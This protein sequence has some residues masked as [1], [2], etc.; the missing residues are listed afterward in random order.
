LAT[1]LM[2]RGLTLEFFYY[3]M[4]G[5]SE[6]Q[7]ADMRSFWTDFHFLPSLPHPEPKFPRHW[8]IDDWCPDVLCETVA[9]L[10]KKR[11]YDAI[12][13]NYVWMS[14]VLEGLEN[15]L[16]IIDT[17]DLFGDRH[18]IS[19]QEGLEPRWFFTS[20]AEEE[21]GFRRADLLIGIQAQETR[22]IQE[23]V[24]VTAITVGHCMHPYF[25]KSFEVSEPLATFGYL[26]SANPWNIK[27]I[28]AL[29]AAL[30]RDN[31][32]VWMLAGS[33]TRRQLNLISRPLILGLVENLVDFYR[34]VDCV[35]NPMMGGTGLKIKTVEALAYG[36]SVIG[37]AD[38]FEGLPALHGFQKLG[39]AHECALAMKEYANSCR[40]REELRA[41]SRTAYLNYA[42]IV[43]REL[44]TLSEMIG[45]KLTKT[46]LSP[47]I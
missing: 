41:A 29:D 38:A 37:T 9:G 28:K 14:R 8:G 40:I 18:L 19:R 16:R 27:C 5:L 31:A 12:L 21:A 7:R 26:G 1:E 3:G 36:R 35:V 30:G 15:T 20:L 17:H 34:C 47:T 6:K 22:N 13:V 10:H 43:A 23:R 4:E 39:D 33:L 44:S 24:G 32:A 25:L 46:I 2:Q 45:P 42:I 11:S